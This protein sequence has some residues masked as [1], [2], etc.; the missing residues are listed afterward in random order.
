MKKQHRLLIYA[1]ALVLSVFSMSIAQRATA[2]FVPDYRFAEI[3]PDHR[4]GTI[5]AYAGGPD[6]LVFD[7]K[8][9]SRNSPYTEALL[10]YLGEH[11]DVGLLM[12]RVRDTVLE[13]TSGRQN[14]VIHM[15]LTGES[16][17][18]AED[19]GVEVSNHQTSPDAEKEE[20]PSRIAL[21]IG[22]DAYEHVGTLETSVNGSEAVAAVLKQLGFWVIQ[23]N[24]VG[25]AEMMHGLVEFR[26]QASEANI[27]II[28]YS[29]L[30]V[31]SSENDRY[32]VPVNAQ[33]KVV[34]HVSYETVQLADVLHA[35]EPASKLR[36]LILDA[37]FGM[38]SA[39]Y[40]VW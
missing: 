1:A 24:N 8:G 17:Y 26:E 38:P 20:G 2:A 32:L 29:G 39:D 33:L 25:Y 9:D 18:L 34:A 30:G 31:K 10:E 5:V 13:L 21:T 15:S 6:G 14:P 11:M 7:G 27:A 28:F 12:R 4:P 37:G 23:L 36:M 3:S 35:L 40:D 16:V 22:N 19:A